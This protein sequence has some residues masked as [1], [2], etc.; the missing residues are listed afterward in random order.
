MGTNNAADFCLVLSIET[1]NLT[2]TKI[3]LTFF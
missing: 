1:M 3:D 2:H